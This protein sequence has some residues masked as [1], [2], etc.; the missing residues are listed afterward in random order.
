MKQINIGIADDHPIMIHGVLSLLK[1]SGDLRVCFTA[2]NI[3]T[4]L[5]LT[6]IRPVD[7]LLCTYEFVAGPK[8]DGLALLARLK[9]LTPRTKVLFLS[10]RSFSHIVTAA[11]DAGAAGFV[12]KTQTDFTNLPEAICEV[13][14]GNVYLSPSLVG[15]MLTAM[16]S[17]K[18]PA[19]GPTSL[20]ADELTV[21]Q[22]IGEG[23]S[24][25]QIA[26]RLDLCT[27]TIFS[28]KAVAMKKLGARN[29]AELTVIVRSLNGRC[30]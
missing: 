7:V 18:G 27:R 16:F 3:Q 15:G 28:K 19:A 11:L 23:L 30:A 26:A 10:T 8:A 13:K 9:R 12:G 24:V 5:A 17:R 21:A 2:D 25:A 20:R 14:R 6:Q 29:D 22:L 1:D 4:L